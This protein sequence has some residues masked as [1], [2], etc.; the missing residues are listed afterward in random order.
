MSLL[1]A[2]LRLMRHAWRYIRVLFRNGVPVLT[3][4]KGFLT[5]LLNLIKQP[6]TILIGIWAFIKSF[7]L[8]PK[9][10]M[11]WMISSAVL[12]LI[13]IFGGGA[14]VVGGFVNSIIFFI[15]DH[16]AEY[17]SGYSISDSWNSTPRVFRAYLTYFGI[18]EAFNTI[19]YC[20]YTIIIA[21]LSWWIR[22]KFIDAGLRVVRF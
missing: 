1:L 13:D 20:L 10:Y 21:H 15:L 6:T 18:I 5:V 9:T 7:I 14:G 8:N 16:A 12:M 19:S 11:L 4:E 22:M 2:I 17:M 3:G